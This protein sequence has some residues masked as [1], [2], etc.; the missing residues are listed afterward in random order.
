MIWFLAVGTVVI[1]AY[2]SGIVANEQRCVSPGD[3]VSFHT[4][5]VS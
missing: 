2:W 5:T 1:G 4:L 3:F